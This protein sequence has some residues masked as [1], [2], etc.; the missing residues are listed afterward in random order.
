MR[1]RFEKRIRQCVPWK[2]SDQKPSPCPYNPERATSTKSAKA[3]QY[4]LGR[5]REEGE[6]EG[7]KE[8]E[9]ICGG[10]RREILRSRHQHD[11]Q[12]TWNA[13]LL[14]S[15]AVS[16]H[17]VSSSMVTAGSVGAFI[18]IVREACSAHFFYKLLF[19]KATEG[20]ARCRRNDRWRQNARQR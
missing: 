17:S 9:K 4:N 20:R 19:C 15:V 6:E 18:R 11:T 3:C 14:N 7:K 8:R 13:E 10:E 2:E 5:R 16:A 12:R 1:L